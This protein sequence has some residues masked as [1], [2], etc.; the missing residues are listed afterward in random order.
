[1]GVC[2]PPSDTTNNS[3]SSTTENVILLSRKRLDQRFYDLQKQDVFQQAIDEIRDEIALRRGSD[4]RLFAM[5]TKL[6]E[7]L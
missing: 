4:A 5:I 7:L 6:S 3:V 2:M 1:M